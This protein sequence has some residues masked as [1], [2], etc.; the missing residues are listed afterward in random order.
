MSSTTWMNGRSWRTIWRGD[1]PPADTAPEVRK[2][3]RPRCTN[4]KAPGGCR[5]ERE[6]PMDISN[7]TALAASFVLALLV[8]KFLIPELRK[9]KAGQSIREDGPTWHAGKAGT[10]TMGG[11]MFIVSTGVVIIILGWQQMLRGEFIH[12]YVYLFALIFGVIGFLDDY[13]KV[14]QHQNEGLTALQKFVLQLGAAVVFLS[15]MRY[16]GLLTNSLYVPFFNVSF[17]I[18]WVVYLIFAAFVIVG[19]VNAVNLTDGIDGLACSVT[20]VVMVFFTVATA[21]YAASMSL[22]P[23]A[24]VGGLAAF[25]AYNHHP[26]RVFMGDTGSLFL[27]GAVAAMAFAMDMPLVLIPVGIIYVAET[28][29]DIIQVAYFKAT[30]GKR[31]FK[32]APLHHHFELCGWSEAKLVTVFSLVTAVGCVLAWFGI[33]GSF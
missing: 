32:M 4:R 30:H 2:A 28:M 3:V 27:G 17:Q 10:P 14:R 25:F 23:A 16:E 18:N 7:L 20:F 13:R 9:L 24:L 5:E 29:S 1:E 15:L 31:F 11:I 8:G 19:T 33:R 12:L 21:Q 22:F 26:A 6:R